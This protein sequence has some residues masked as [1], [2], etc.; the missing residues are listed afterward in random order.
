MRYL[1]SRRKQLTVSGVFYMP[2]FKKPGKEKQLNASAQCCKITIDDLTRVNIMI[3]KNAI[4]LKVV[5][6]IAVFSFFLSA[7]PA[8]AEKYSKV[9]IQIQKRLEIR[10]L[11]KA[12][13]QFDHG[14]LEKNPAGGYLYNVIVNSAELT[15]LQNS[16]FP[17]KLLIPDMKKAYQKRASSI[18]MQK[19]ET[20]PAGFEYGS[21]GSYYTFSEVAT[22]LDSM[23][24]MYPDLITQKQSLGVTENGNDIWMVKISA[25]P[26]VD[27][28]EPEV[29]YTALHHAREPES[30]MA[31]LYFMDHILEQYGSDPEITYLLN[32]RELYFI[33]VVNPDGYLYNEQT[34][35][36]GGGYWRKNRRN[37]GD[38]SYGVDLNRNYGYEWG[39]DD[40]G[41]SPTPS[42]DTYRGPFAF[43][44]PETQ[45]IRDF[46]NQRHFILAFNYHTYSNLLIVPW[47]YIGDFLTPDSLVYD[48]YGA[49][50]TQ[51]NNYTYGT[52][53]NTVGYLVNGDSD[54]WMYGEQS[55]KNKIFAFTP[56]I[57]TDADGFWPPEERIIPLAEENIY[58]NLVMARAAG[59]YAKYKGYTLE[60][61]GD[62]NGYM[63]AGEEAGLTFEIQNAGQ[64]ISNDVTLTLSSTD[65]YIS[66][67]TTQSSTP[68]DIA[69][70]QTI[71]SSS[72]YFSAAENT[73]AGYEPELTLTVSDDGLETDYLIEGIVI[74]TP[75]IIFAD[76]AENGTGNWDKG[77]SWNITNTS[78]Y[79]GDYSF[80]DSPAG[81]YGNDKI[82][83]LTLI[84]P[85]E[86]P[87]AGK[88]LL[89]FKTHWSIE[90]E[91]DFAKVQ[92]STNGSSWT[93][94]QGK[95][96]TQGSGQGE[97]STDEYGYDGLQSE[98]VDEQFDITSYASSAAF[99]L[100]FDLSSDQAEVRDGWYLDEIEI[101][102]YE[103]SPSA[104]QAANTGIPGTFALQQNYPN[105][106]NPETVINYEL[107]IANFVELTV[108]NTLGQ[109][110][111]TL[112]SGR[113]EAGRY[114]IR[115]DV[116]GLTSGVYLYRLSTD[117][118]FVQTKKMIL[119]H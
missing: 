56:E 62:L 108:Y 73:P 98:W 41:S 22:E 63:D 81:N 50:M 10:E 43:S 90:A 110:V 61:K 29:L 39:Y 23:Y 45:V 5:L 75:Q 114:S 12:G 100:R 68:V 96:T 27:E 66:I 53:N 59:G 97:Q 105:P 67:I 4:L 11:A 70:R 51:F 9:Q 104:V 89:K 8:Q 20:V 17:Y 24:L 58:Q 33:P 65:P 74:G 102:A 34:D 28:D 15:I 71:Y 64:G 87:A 117:D 101:L 86:L 118:G 113:Q 91:W 55:T 7:V 18:E 107:P 78:V 48:D 49:D 83:R 60:D 54:D 19:T 69:S 35:P 82:N 26:T 40:S 3:S 52:G 88:I 94:I 21:M 116:N 31:L 112:V 77:L 79:S 2:E 47:G 16:R 109:K 42:S 14:R 6:I 84:N 95:Y 36:N 13:L 115:F 119:I 103:E 38:G 93:T 106:F 85:L 57:G 44:E 80:T 1:T 76:N 46:C 30:I 111:R 32:N 72:F 37:N 99:Y 25:N 92:V